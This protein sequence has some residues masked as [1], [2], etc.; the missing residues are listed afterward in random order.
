MSGIVA[1]DGTLWV[2]GE[3]SWGMIRTNGGFHPRPRKLGPIEDWRQMASSGGGYVGLRRDGSVW[4]WRGP[5]RIHGAVS[6]PDGTPEPLV[7]GTNWIQVVGG[8]HRFFL[9]RADG[10]LFAAGD[11]SDGQLGDGT[12]VT[13]DHFVPVASGQRWSQVAV[14]PDVTTAIDQDGVLWQWGRFIGPKPVPRGIPTHWSNVAAHGMIGVGRTLSGNFAVWG[15]TPVEEPGKAGERSSAP[16]SLIDD[17]RGWSRVLA[18]DTALLAYDTRDESWHWILG[19]PGSDRF[20]FNNTAR[21]RF[22]VPRDVRPLWM[23]NSGE[24]F[25]GWSD[26]GRL[27]VRGRPLDDEVGILNIHRWKRAVA[28]WFRRHQIDSAALHRW[29][30]NTRHYNTNFVPVA[31]F[32]SP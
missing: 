28:E 2:W 8:L 14:T 1:P 10:G 17:T 30:A 7:P 23:E 19:F 20:P 22:P 18:T 21:P 26:D 4:G 13:R 15:I 24:R 9:L 16:P 29:S 3:D 11:N 32:V 5:R 31:R 27:W 6:L 12:T 25:Y